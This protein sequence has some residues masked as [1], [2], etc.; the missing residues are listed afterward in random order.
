MSARRGPGARRLIGGLAAL[1]AAGGLA[2]ATPTRYGHLGPDGGYSEHQLDDGAWEVTF[3]GN[4]DSTS[5]ELRRLLRYRCAELTVASGADF[6]VVVRRESL[7]LPGS[8]PAESRRGGGR[9]RRG[10][11]ASAGGAESAAQRAQPRGDAAARPAEAVLI[12]MARGERPEL[13]ED[14]RA[15][16]REL[17]PAIPH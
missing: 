11:G 16:L 15:T 4:P 6:F 8:A 2:C 5:D 14:A 17:G 9:G 10:G 7:S 1:L 12:R 3:E 13:G